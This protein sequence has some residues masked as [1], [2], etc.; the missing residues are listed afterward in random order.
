[1][2]IE[3]PEQIAARLTPEVAALNL[4]LGLYASEEVTLEQGSRIAR[5]SQPEFLKELGKRRIPFH[6][7]IEEFEEDMATISRKAR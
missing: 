3:M 6:Y 2:V 5:M 1:M 7:G 4:A